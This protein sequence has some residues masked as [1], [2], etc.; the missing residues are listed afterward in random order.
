[1]F[2]RPLLDRNR[3]SARDGFEGHANFLEFPMVFTAISEFPNIS[4]PRY[5]VYTTRGA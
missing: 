3:K 5:V 4:D 1:M 2:S